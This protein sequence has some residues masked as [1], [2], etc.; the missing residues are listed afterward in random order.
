MR[1]L[2]MFGNVC[3]HAHTRVST[4]LSLFYCLFASLQLQ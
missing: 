4:L 2:F 1:T 3:T